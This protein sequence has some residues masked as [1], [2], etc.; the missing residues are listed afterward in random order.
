[1]RFITLILKRI[2]GQ[3]IHK[4]S[5]I[6]AWEAASFELRSE[7]GEFKEI[8]LASSEEVIVDEIQLKDLIERERYKH[9]YTRKRY[10]INLSCRC[11]HRITI[12]D[13]HYHPTHFV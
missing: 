10:L 4:Y 2:F 13:D 7:T 3:H 11:G 12:Q 8:L 5:F 6:Q 1:M 9:I